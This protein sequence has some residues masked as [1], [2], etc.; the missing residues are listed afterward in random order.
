M[1]VPPLKPP[2][3]PLRGKPPVSGDVA[4]T[5]VQA[6]VVGLAIALVGTLVAGIVLGMLYQL[7]LL[8]AGMSDEAASRALADLGPNSLVGVLAMLAGAL[9]TV[10]GGFACARIVMRDEYRVALV[11]AVLVCLLDSGD[12]PLDLQALQLA[13]DFACVMLGAMYGARRNRRPPPP[14]TAPP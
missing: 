14:G 8:Q 6:V 11:M 3:N 2:D 1:P 13:S 12:G 10:A 4:G 9:C 5:P 7:W